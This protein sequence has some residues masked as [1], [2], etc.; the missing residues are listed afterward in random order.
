MSKFLR[1]LVL[2]ALLTGA[3]A[4]P[5]VAQDGFAL[6]AGYIYNRA[7]AEGAARDAGVSGFGAGVEYVLPIVGVGVG[8]SAYTG[9]RVTDFDVATSNVNVVAEANY[10]LKLPVIPIAPYAGV[11]AGLGQYSQAH[12][13]TPGTRPQDGW[14]QLGFQAGVRFQLISLFGVDAQ[15]RRV[16]TSLANEQGDGLARNQVVVGVTL[17]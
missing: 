16:S 7:P 1:A 14:R 8:L 5:A 3:V 12:D 6:K 17:F 11:H 9:G 10:F 15:F 13:T 4:A 2:G